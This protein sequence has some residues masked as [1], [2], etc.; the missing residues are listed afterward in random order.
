MPDQRRDDLTS[1]FESRAATYVN[2]LPMRREHDAHVAH[3][4][5]ADR[6]LLDLE[7]LHQIGVVELHG[8]SMTEKEFCGANNV[9]T[10]D[11]S[12][13]AHL[14]IALEVVPN[15]YWCDVLLTRR[16]NH[17]AS[18]RRPRLGY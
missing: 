10:V 13:Q 1:R 6:K 11:H 9:L 12:H 5:A 15:S 18:S 14:R 17:A 3:R 7:A 8:L 2:E 16:G 4:I